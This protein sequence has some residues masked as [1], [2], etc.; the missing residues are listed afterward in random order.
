MRKPFACLLALVLALSTLGTVAAAESL[1]PIVEDESIEL[2]YWTG[3]HVNALVAISSYEE[4]EAYQEIMKRTGVKI[5]FE[6]PASG[7]ESTTLSLLIAGGEMPDIIS[8][9]VNGL[10]TGGLIAAMDEGV[11]ADLTG[12]LPANAPDYWGF[13]EGDPLFMTTDGR[14]AA[15]YRYTPDEQFAPPWRRLMTRNEWIKEAGA[16]VPDTIAEMEDYFQWILDNKE[17]V[18]PIMPPTVGSGYGMLLMGT[19]NIIDG[20]YVNLDGEVAWGRAAGE[21]YR[22]YLTKMNEWYQKG[23]TSPDWATLTEEDQRSAYIAGTVAVTA[24]SCDD[25]RSMALTAGFEP[26]SFPYLKIEEGAVYHGDVLNSN[27]GGDQTVISATCKNIEAAVKFLNYGYTE[28]GRMIY[29]FGIQG[30][31]WD[32]DEAGVPKY[33]ER[34][35]YPE[36]FSSENANYILR[37]HFAP[38]HGFSD[39]VANPSVVKDADAVAFRSLWAD[40]PDVDNVLRMPVGVVLTSDESAR[41]AEIMTDINTYSSECMAKFI[42]G[43][44]SLDAYDAYLETLYA[45]GLQEAIDITIAAYE[46]YMANVR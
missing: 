27:N 13:V 5:K 22:A 32:Y 21:D 31:S 36:K 7:Q 3:I 34:M 37:V 9:N 40:D 11:V 8:Y 44:T 28:E 4:N 6:H 43:E 14:Y 16:G 35:T 19:Y 45:M 2:V 41:R 42:N 15:F 38:K 46:R 25:Y 1:Y 12:Y 29:S 33:Y 23:Y 18:M 10:Y 30:L 17:G 24:G 26:M 20:W 39:L